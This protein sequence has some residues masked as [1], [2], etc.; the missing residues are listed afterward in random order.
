MPE[1]SHRARFAGPRSRRARWSP[2]VSLCGAALLLTSCGGIGSGPPDPTGGR[3]TIF[4]LP[5]GAQ[6]QLIRDR[7]EPSDVVMTDLTGATH[8]LAAL[9]GKVVL[10]NFWATWCGPCRQEIPDLM[11][12][13]ARYGE[14]VEI[15]GVSLDEGGAGVV[16]AFADELQISYPL[17]MSTPEITQQ[18]PGVFALPTTFVLDPQGGIAQ[19][20][21]GLIN[22]AILEWEIRYL[23]GLDETIQVALVEAEKPRTLAEAAQATEIPGLDLSGLTAEQR[24]TALQR[25]NED[26]CTCG[27]GLTLASCRINDPSCGFSLPLAEELV[28]EIVA[29]T[30][31]D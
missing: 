26:G 19:T 8:S 25:L 16:E 24:E 15:I 20:H 11:A 13:R 1:M 2:L 21:V 27:C 4:Q 28:A 30:D 29:D 7:V 6:L 12:L 17:V 3:D 18:F 10:M 23:A 31:A 22:P 9:R 5:A 14:Q